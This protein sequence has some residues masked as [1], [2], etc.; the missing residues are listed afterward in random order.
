[1]GDAVVRLGLRDN[2]AQFSLLVV[3]NAFVGAMVGLERSILP[4]IAEQEIQ[5]AARAAILSFI[6]AFGDAKAI[7]RN[8]GHNAGVVSQPGHP[9]RSYRV[10]TRSA[11]GVTWTRTSGR[12]TRRARTVRGG[13]SG[14]LFHAGSLMVPFSASTPQ[15]TCESAEDVH[16]ADLLADHEIDRRAL[17]AE[18]P[19]C[20]TWASTGLLCC[21]P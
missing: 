19:P 12:R 15:G 13:P 16:A 2:L 14:F 6:V 7:R 5:V 11:E 17:L 4:V 8:G 9:G 3:A 18:F 20:A 1:M 21:S 10:A